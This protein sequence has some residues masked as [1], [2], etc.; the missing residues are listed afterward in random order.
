MTEDVYYKNL[1]AIGDAARKND[2]DFWLF[3]QSMSWND[4]RI[5]DLEDLRFQAYSAIAYGATKLMHF[6][7]SNPHF[8]DGY[9]AVDVEGE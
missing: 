6:C 5:P 8:P 3:I 7:Y 1:K 4:R 2:A 9:S